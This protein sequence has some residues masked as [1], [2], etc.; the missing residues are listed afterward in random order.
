MCVKHGVLTWRA[1]KLSCEGESDTAPQLPSTF[2]CLDRVFLSFFVFLGDLF[3]I[4]FGFGFFFFSYS[5]AAVSFLC[6]I[7]YDL[8][9]E[10]HGVL[11][12]GIHFAVN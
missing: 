1:R 12:S 7:C 10:Q 3:C 11:N 5:A 6:D 9:I 4:V 8:R 2:L